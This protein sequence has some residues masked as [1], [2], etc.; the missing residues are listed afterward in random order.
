MLLR[1]LEFRDIDTLNRFQLGDGSASGLRGD[2]R[3]LIE[4]SIETLENDGSSIWFG[5]ES[6]EHELIGTAAFSTKAKGFTCYRLSG[7]V[8]TQ[9]SVPKNST[10]MGRFIQPKYR[11][12]GF[13]NLALFG[14]FLFLFAHPKLFE[15]QFIGYLRGVYNKEG[16]NS[17]WDHVISPYMPEHFKNLSYQ[18]YA[19]I[20]R[21]GREHEIIQFLPDKPFRLSDIPESAR[22]LIGVA[23][24]ETQ[25]MFNTLPRQGFRWR[26]LIDYSSAAPIVEAGIDDFLVIGC[27]PFYIRVDEHKK[28]GSAYISNKSTIRFRAILAD[29]SQRSHDEICISKATADSLLVNEGEPVLLIEREK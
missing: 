20:L 27:K 2:K 22:T 3:R 9:A 21:E 23:H 7:E 4:K 10:F 25:Q 26:G 5:I 16:Y 13:G 14:R 6:D 29:F 18:Q 12:R 15:K 8:I 19:Q 24:P 28:S 17:W 11:H 1:P